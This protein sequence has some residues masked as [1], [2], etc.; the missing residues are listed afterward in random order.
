MKQR[1]LF[2]LCSMLV[3]SGL[4]S[5]QGKVVTNSDLEKFKQKRLQAEQELKEYYAKQGLTEEDIAKRQAADAKALEEL[6][7]RLR[8]NRLEQERLEYEARE[9]E[10]AVLQVNTTTPG[11]EYGYSGF[12][13]YGNRFY[14][15]SPIWNRPYNNGVTWRATPMGVIYEPGSRP[16][17][18]WSPPL[19]QR[20]MPAWR[21]PRPQ[22]P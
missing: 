18:I 16:S 14:R 15:N 13:L 9:R 19:R 1:V 6:S 11:Y 5:A 20:P 2:F 10:A 21:N 12:Y 8:A 7:A 22:R 17:T 4:A 3:F